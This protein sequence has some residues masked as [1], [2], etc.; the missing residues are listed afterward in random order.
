M[1][2]RR[3]HAAVHLRFRAEGLGLYW[4]YIGLYRGYIGILSPN[5]GES[6]GKEMEDDMETEII[7]LGDIGII[8]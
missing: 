4:I 6:N 5:N 2:H 1:K 7:Q 8:V 3:R